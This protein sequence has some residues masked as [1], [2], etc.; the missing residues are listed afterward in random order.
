MV[1]HNKAQSKKRN[2][3]NNPLHAPVASPAN[4]RDHIRGVSGNTRVSLL[5]ARVRYTDTILNKNKSTIL[6]ILISVS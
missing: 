3:Q 1:S 4:A 5:Q 6:K 2:F